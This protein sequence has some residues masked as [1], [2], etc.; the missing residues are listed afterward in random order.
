M[1][2]AATRG[3]RLEPALGERLLGGPR[4]STDRNRLQVHAS[5]I[6]RKDDEQLVRRRQ[7]VRPWSELRQHDEILV[8]SLS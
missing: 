1:D 4:I 6:A 3:L 7:Y 8:A 5:P 2:E